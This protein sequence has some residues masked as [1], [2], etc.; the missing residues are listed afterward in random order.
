MIEVLKKGKGKENREC[1]FP[2]RECDSLLRARICDGETFHNQRDG[3]Y[4]SFLCPVC[5]QY[6]YVDYGEFK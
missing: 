5:N 3:S 1:E 4:V 6:I 2:C